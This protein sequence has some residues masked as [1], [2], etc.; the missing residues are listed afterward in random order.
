MKNDS[1]PDTKR[2]EIIYSAQNDE[3]INVLAKMVK[4]NSKNALSSDKLPQLNELVSEHINIFRTAFPSGLPADI[5]PLKV[6]LRANETS[7]S[8]WRLCNYSWD[9]KEYLACMVSK[10]VESCL[11]NANP[12]L[13][14]ASAPLLVPNPGPVKFLL[15]V[16]LRPESCFT[17]RIQYLM[18]NIEP[19]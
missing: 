19:K 16:D 12:S 4:D 2:S 5:A 13:S 11:D 1:L 15:S 17:V 14:W 10:I 8:V 6:D 9:Q 18:P 3:V 7:V